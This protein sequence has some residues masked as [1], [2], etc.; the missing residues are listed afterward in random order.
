MIIINQNEDEFVNF[1][2]IMNITVTD[3]DEDGFGIFA[4]FIIGRD[5]NYRELGI[6]KTKERADEIFREIIF[7]YK[8]YKLDNNRGVYQKPKVY[9]MPKE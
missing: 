4:G 8:Q 9:E 5:D 1:D 6:Y 2:N 7:L 3:C